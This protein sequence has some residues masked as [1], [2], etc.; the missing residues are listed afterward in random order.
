MYIPPPDFWDKVC[1]DDVRARLESIDVPFNS[2]GYDRFGISR[3]HLGTFYTLLEPLYR[4]YFKVEVFGAEHIPVSSR[5][6]L[7]GNHSGGVPV[8]AAMIF[9]SLFFDLDPPRHAHGMVEK[10]AQNL[11]F[12]SAIF[13]RLGQL[14]GL[15][16]HAHQI[17]NQE[18]ILLVF[19]EGVRGTGKLYK[20][21]YQLERFGTGFMRIALQ[22]KSP[23]IP[24]AFIG[25]EEA[26]PVIY[27]AKTLAQLFKVPYFPVPKHILPIPKPELCQIHYG[28][29]LHFEGDGNE[30]D[31]VIQGHVDDVKRAIAELIEIGRAQRDIRVEA[32]TRERQAQRGGR[33]ENLRRESSRSESTPPTSS[34]RGGES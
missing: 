23:I 3:K 5:G 9:A 24:F 26:M 19:P 20:D 27:H 1:S 13:S 30:S 2:Y 12:L 14:S 25:G 31:E 10:F 17:L 11:P 22:N 7:I 34:S 8:D 21:R 18:R 33:M 4:K 28:P 29:P 15:P 6:M 16:E 32:L